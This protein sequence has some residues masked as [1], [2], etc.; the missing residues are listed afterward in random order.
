VI[1]L[2]LRA[3]AYLLL[4]AAF[5]IAVIDATRSIEGEKLVLTP[6]DRAPTLLLATKPG[7]FEIF[8][9]DHVPG[10]LWDPFSVTLLG[11]PA[12]LVLATIA[13]ILFRLA[14]QRRRRLGFRTY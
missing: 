10:F 8:V 13:G 6:L 9:K 2:A 14:R 1:G 4:A 5:A 7:V 12:A 11:L 3:I